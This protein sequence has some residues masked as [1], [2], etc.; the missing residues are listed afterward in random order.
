ML[1]T[2]QGILLLVATLLPFAGEA[3]DITVGGNA[4]LTVHS[5]IFLNGG[6][7]TV[8]ADG[9]VALSGGNITNIGSVTLSAGA[10]LT[11]PGSLSL[12]NNWINDS[13]F[14]CPTGTIDLIAIHIPV[15]SNKNHAIG[16][17]D[18]DGDGYSDRGEGCWDHEPDGIPD[19]LDPGPHAMENPPDNW[20][21]SNQL[22]TDGS[23]D[24]I[25]S[26]GD[27]ASNWEEYHADTD[28]NNPTSVLQITS[29]H[30]VPTG[31]LHIA[32]DTVVPK[33]YLLRASTNALHSNDFTLLIT[34]VT[35][36]DTSHS[37]TSSLPDEAS[38]GYIRVHVVP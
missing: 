25:D 28:P 17:G 27:G 29:I 30:S 11:G 18:T 26:D 13:S 22:P 23:A 10:V 8:A 9:T 5:N 36:D 32:W 2:R 14:V 35:A 16:H 20:M 33:Q 38:R 7:L 21:T 3:A 31:L 24:H 1:K 37:V 15:H 4:T 34:N 19:F 12:T 6:D